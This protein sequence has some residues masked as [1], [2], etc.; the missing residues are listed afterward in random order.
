M[1]LK[2]YVYG[3]NIRIVPSIAWEMLAAQIHQGKYC[4]SKGGSS[5]KPHALLYNL[6][7]TSSFYHYIILEDGVEGGL[8]SMS[9]ISV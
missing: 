4:G 2:F 6:Q 3:P 8:M 9:P 5:P 1:V 7:S